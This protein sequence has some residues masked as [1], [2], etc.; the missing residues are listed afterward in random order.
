MLT[1]ILEYSVGKDDLVL[2]FF[3][4]SGTTGHAV[5]ALNRTDGGRRRCISVNLPELTPVGS[6]ARQAGYA[7][8]SEITYARLRA[9]MT[10][11]SDDQG[12]RVFRLAESGFEASLPVEPDGLFNLSESTL[13]EPDLPIGALAAEIL[14][15]EGIRLDAPWKRTKAGDA[16]TV[17]ADGVLVVLSLELED[18]TVDAALSLESR[19]LVF[20]EDGFARKDLVKV[21]AFTKAR[22]LGITMK[23]V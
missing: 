6:D 13:V 22:E 11:N 18:E 21:N 5:S 10:E 12:L 2:D 17:G 4:G 7:T 9:A 1:Q 16:W 14:I 15:K 8:V 3:A 23:T 19:V 20:L